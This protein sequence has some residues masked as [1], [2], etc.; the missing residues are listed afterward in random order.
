[1]II[2]GNCNQHT[3]GNETQKI[4]RE[5][6]VQDILSVWEKIRGTIGMKLSN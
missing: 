1:M 5:I 2:A 3:R 4:Y 6:G